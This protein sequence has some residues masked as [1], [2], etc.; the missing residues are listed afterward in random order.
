MSEASGALAKSE[1]SF[2]SC[3][4][5]CWE[6]EYRTARIRY[7]SN[8]EEGR[9]RNPQERQRLA[10]YIGN[11]IDRWA[12][13]RIDKA[14]TMSN[15]RN[16]PLPWSPGSSPKKWIFEPKKRL[17]TLNYDLAGRMGTEMVSSKRDPIT[18]KTMAEG[19]DDRDEVTPA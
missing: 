6:D 17:T 2:Q 12:S 4:E 8:S 15:D 18:G 19:G 16:V 13:R 11:E 10:E 5:R 7:A 14:Q 3:I 1:L 9:Q